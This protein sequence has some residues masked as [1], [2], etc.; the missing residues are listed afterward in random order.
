MK[1]QSY[2]ALGSNVG[3]KLKNINSALKEIKNNP[4]CELVTL[5]SIYETGPY[6]YTKQENFLNAA[7]EISTNL[8]L[9]SLFGFLKSIEE[10]LGRLKTIKWGPRV[11]D[12]DILFYNNIIYNDNVITVPHKGIPE[13][14][15]VLVPL[16]E[17]AP[18]LVHPV[19][20][21]KISD[22]CSDDI[23]KTIIR[24]FQKG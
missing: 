7:A 1:N 3:D 11:I 20:N 22:I 8:D 6:G 14:D 10:K 21:R 12:I 23:Q 16:S 4:D 5:S 9:V 15:F 13:R 2:I 17:I 18:D 24:I 19:L